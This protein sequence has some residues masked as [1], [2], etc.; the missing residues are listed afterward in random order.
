MS[1]IKGVQQTSAARSWAL[2]GGTAALATGW[3]YTALV[4]K[5]V[6]AGNEPRELSPQT[7]LEAF[8]QGGAG[9]LYFSLMA[10][11]WDNAYG[12][13]AA[14]LA[15]PSF[16]LIQDALGAGHNMLDVARYAAEGDNPKAKKAAS[17]LLKKVYDHSPKLPLIGNAINRTILEATQRSMDLPVS[18]R[19]G[20][21]LWQ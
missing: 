8:D 10:K 7:M 6:A 13:L 15:G 17:K 12:S 1:S 20:K 4:L 21:P 19:K 3:G 5:D 2:T 18:K 11:D 16:K 9:G 14:D